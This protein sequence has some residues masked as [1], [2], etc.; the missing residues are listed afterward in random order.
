MTYYIVLRNDISSISVFV[1]AEKPQIMDLLTSSN[2]LVEEGDPV[3][4]TCNC[5][6]W[7]KPNVKWSKVAGGLLPSGGQ[8]YAVRHF[9]FFYIMH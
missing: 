3:Q 4:L 5:T 7:P 6:G 8:E 9:H 1:L 2:Q